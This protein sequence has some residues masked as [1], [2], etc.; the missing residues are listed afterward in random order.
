MGFCLEMILTDYSRHYVEAMKGYREQSIHLM[1][2][3]Q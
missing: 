1:L 3:K 2:E